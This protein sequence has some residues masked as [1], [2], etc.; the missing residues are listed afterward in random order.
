MFKVLLVLSALLFVSWA[1][2]VPNHPSC[3]SP[4]GEIVQHLP[5]ANC[6]KFYKCHDGDACEFKRKAVA[7]SL[8][9]NAMN[10]DLRVKKEAH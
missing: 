6:N 4:N 7:G 3:I 1:Q 5:H 8:F 10:L 9:V 2:D